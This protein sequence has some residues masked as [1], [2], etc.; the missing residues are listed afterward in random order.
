MK[1]VFE[2]DILEPIWSSGAPA[3]TTFSSIQARF[4]VAA[5]DFV[6]ELWLAATRHAHIIAHR[7]YDQL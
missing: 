1:F 7:H 5:C 3:L 2:K 6:A 4:Y